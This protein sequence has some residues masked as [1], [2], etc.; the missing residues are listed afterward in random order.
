MARA[1]WIFSGEE[2]PGPAQPATNTTAV[3]DMSSPC[4]EYFDDIIYPLWF[5]SASMYRGELATK[6]P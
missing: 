6:L 1:F 3:R 5:L 4:N 2:A